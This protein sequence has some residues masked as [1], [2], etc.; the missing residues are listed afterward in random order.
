MMARYIVA[1]AERS[2]QQQAA[3]KKAINGLRDR[4]PYV[5][6]RGIGQ[7]RGMRELP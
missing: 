3:I 4:A 5:N 6:Y 7:I 2:N 1:S